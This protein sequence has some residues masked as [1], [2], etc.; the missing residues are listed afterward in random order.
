MRSSCSLTGLPKESWLEVET[1]RDPSGAC[2]TSRTRPTSPS[3]SFSLHD[4]AAGV[5]LQA[6]EPLSPESSHEKV[7]FPLRDGPFDH[8]LRPARGG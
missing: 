3:R 5:Q 8:D 4:L 7:A 2:M 1:H 6:P